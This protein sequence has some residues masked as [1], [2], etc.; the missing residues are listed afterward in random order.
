MD[1]YLKI[2]GM[3]SLKTHLLLTSLAVE[4][5]E[6]NSR[7]LVMVGIS[8]QEGM[9]SIAVRMNQVT[10]VIAALTVVLTARR[11]CLTPSPNSEEEEAKEKVE[12]LEIWTSSAIQEEVWRRPIF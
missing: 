6:R 11:I 8:F 4:E 7:L 1:M 2:K 3:D 12:E 9:S 10:R 5:E